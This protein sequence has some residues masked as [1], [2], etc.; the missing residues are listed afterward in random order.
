MERMLSGIKPTGKLTLGNYL[1]AIRN[2]VKYQDEYELFVF[3]ANMHAIT[4]PQDRQELKKNTYDLAALYLACGLDP[5]K[6]TLFLQTDILE[7]ANLGFV[8]TCHT[9]MGELN[10]MTQYKDKVSK[11]ED[12]SIGVGLF[13]YPTLMAAD[14]L[15]YDPQYI[16]VGDDQKQHVELTRDIAQR[17]NNR[18][19]ETFIVPKPVVAKTGARIMSLS[20]PTKKMSKS[21]DPNDKGCIYLLDDPKVAR[22]KIMSAV[23]DMGMEVKYDV[24]NKPGISN[25][26]TIYACLTDLTIEEIEAKYVGVNYGTFKKELADILEN[27]LVNLQAKYKEIIDAKIVEK[28]FEDGANKVRPIARK[29]MYKVYKKL[30]LA[31]R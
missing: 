17:F 25:L 28:V 10:R 23:T 5:E 15:L 22:K 12:A 21:D 13:T 8:L 24:E 7:H 16:P 29:K 9:Y 27:F 4:V 26:M 14:I 6:T 31:I 11:L 30:G 19:G 20:N 1:G 3:I 18:H 2:F